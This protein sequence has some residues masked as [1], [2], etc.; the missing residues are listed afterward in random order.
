M[1]I[2]NR[3]NLKKTRQRL[4]NNMTHAEVL[5]WTQLKGKSLNGLKFRRQHSID[6]YII[7]FYC[8]EKKFAIEVDGPTHLTK[9]AIRHDCEK[10]NLLRDLDINVLRVTNEEIYDDVLNVVDRISEILK[11]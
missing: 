11:Y 3:K 6:K 8:P 4:R 5:L 1:N 7:D 10:H 9:D 2:H